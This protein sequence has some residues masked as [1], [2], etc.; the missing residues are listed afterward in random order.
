VSFGV[1][2]DV[3]GGCLAYDAGNGFGRMELINQVFGA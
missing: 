2:G 3:G 1:G